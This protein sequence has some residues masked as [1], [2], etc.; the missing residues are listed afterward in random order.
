MFWRKYE[1]CS[2]TEVNLLTDAPGLWIH[3]RK[4]ESAYF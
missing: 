2:V 3:L 1:K 4:T